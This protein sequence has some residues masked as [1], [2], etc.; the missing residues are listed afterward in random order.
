LIRPLVQRL[1]R[2]WAMCTAVMLALITAGSLWP[3]ETLPEVG[4]DKAA[5]FLS[6]ALLV[7]PSSLRR[8]A[9]APLLW[10]ALLAWSGLIELLQPYV[11]RQ[12]ELADLAANGL[13]MF[14][15]ILLARVLVKSPCRF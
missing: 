7:L 14:F 5:H 1:I 2:H 10:G 9:R 3:Q 4:G 15:G 6:Y 8:P 11:N 12:A 13:G